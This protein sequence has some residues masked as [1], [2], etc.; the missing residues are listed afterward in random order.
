VVI[1]GFST[2]YDMAGLPKM[3]TIS[4]HFGNNYR[5]LLALPEAPSCGET[6]RI[7]MHK[8][9]RRNISTENALVGQL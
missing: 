1:Y 6:I 2:L 3:E 9:L 4:T 7:R 8:M 5:S